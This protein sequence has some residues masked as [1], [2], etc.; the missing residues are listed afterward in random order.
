MEAG[1]GRDEAAAC[2]RILMIMS[3]LSSEVWERSRE[4]S[5]CSTMSPT[6]TMP[7]APA[8]STVVEEPRNHWPPTKQENALHG[9]LATPPATPENS[10]KS[11]NATPSPPPPDTRNL[12]YDPTSPPYCFVDEINR[13]QSTLFEDPRAQAQL[14]WFKNVVDTKPPTY[15][16][17]LAPIGTHIL[18]QG[19]PAQTSG[20]VKDADFLAGDCK[21]LEDWL[22][23]GTGD[24]LFV[25][26]DDEWFNTRPSLTGSEFFQELQAKGMDKTL[27]LEVQELGKQIGD[28]NVNAVQPMT[29]DKILERW[30]IRDQSI[31]PINLLNLM[32]KDDAYQPWPLAKYCNLLNQAAA[33]SASIAQS[34]FYATAGKESTEVMTKVID[35]EACMHF[36]IFGQAGAIST[37]HM[38]AIGPYTY[39]TLEPNQE[40][41]PPDHVLKL[42]AYVRTDHLSEAERAEIKLRFKQDHE[43]FQPNP[44]HIRI[45]ALVAGDT[46][47][48]PPGT[49][50]AP[51]TITDCLFRGGMVMQKRQMW[52]SMR[53]WRFCSDND[54]CTNE[55]QPR[56]ARS[57]LDFFRR[58]V[59]AN[60]TA[61]GY[62]GENG[63]AAF[64]ND[65][66][67]LSGASMVCS[68]KAGCK[69][70]KCGCQ[71]NTQRCGSQCHGGIAK[72]ENPYGCEVDTKVET[73]EQAPAS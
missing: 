63:V 68:C 36:L 59:Y 24:K 6:P 62:G 72:C 10:G 65:W 60:P 13:E 51:I 19:R 41:Q 56:Q 35:L 11:S 2:A 58:E 18:E 70:R 12:P 9:A 49:I 4:Q 71:L 17:E 38:D 55:N 21:V 53:E 29:I 47:I 5:R 44:E 22:I 1:V 33:S 43:N 14:Q 57:I 34:A 25:L 16:S 61:C 8:M 30:S 64:E 50:H 23:N 7:S 3:N 46:L 26:R 69:T 37:W 39:I 20:D 52:R 45:L 27:L 66:R 32:C 48:M 31:P 28:P 40:G 67:K 42:W 15:Y 54:R 73:K